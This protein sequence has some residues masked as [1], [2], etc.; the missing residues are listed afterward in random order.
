M[1][2]KVDSKEEALALANDVPFGL[3]S[4]V[5]T[6]DEA[7]AAFFVDGIEAGITAINTL[8]FSDARVPFGGVKRSGYGRELADIGLREFVNIKTVLQG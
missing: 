2:F 6:S 8:V 5:W 3:G 1:L 7:E 4:S